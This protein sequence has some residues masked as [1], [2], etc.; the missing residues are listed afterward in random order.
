[1][2][3][4]N[5]SLAMGA[6]LDLQV[7]TAH[8]MNGAYSFVSNAALRIGKDVLEV[9]SDGSHYVNGV[10]VDLPA[11]VG[12]FLVTRTVEQVC[13]GK[14]LKRCSDVITFN[15]PLLENDALRIKVASSMIHVDVK[16]SDKG[17]YG[18][19]G[20]MGT[21]P[22]EH[23]GKIAR[24][25]ETYLQDPNIFAQEWQVL[26]SEPKLFRESRYPQHPQVCIPAIQTISAERRLW[27]EDSAIR[28]AAE[29]A[30]SHVEGPEW[31]FCIF[32]VTATSDY[33]LEQRETGSNKIG[34]NKIAKKGKNDRRARIDKTQ[35]QESKI[36]M[37]GEK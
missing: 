10:H 29:E 35:R 11:T 15:I 37:R 26:E 36:T 31:E 16:G 8:M 32:D 4:H 3:V 24:D 18:S 1:M 23:H 6:G 9:I 27:E 19:S 20:L 13:K 33:V 5:P 22:S 30:C 12:G 17:F 2:L 28:V 25:G 34:L 21:Y 7:R 14:E